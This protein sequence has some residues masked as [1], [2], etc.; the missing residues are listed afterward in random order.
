MKQVGQ[1]VR[2]I[3]WRAITSGRFAYTAD[4]ARD[5]VLHGQILR[6][7]HPFARILAIDVTAAMAAPGVRAVITAADFPAGARYLHEGAADRPPLA[8]GWVRFVGQEVAAVAADSPQQAQAALRLIR[9]RYRPLRKAPAT[10][11]A[12]RRIGAAKLHER[13]TGQANLS[14]AYERDWGD[15]D[16]GRRASVHVRSADYSFPAQ[17]HAC[18]EPAVTLADWSDQDERLQLWTST[19][20]PYYVVREVAKVMGLEERQVVCRE[21]GAGGSFGAR[22][23]VGDHEA[24]AGLLSRRAG[25]PVLIELTREEDFS[26]TKTRHAFQISLRLGGDAAHR[27]RLIEGDVTVDNGAYNH[28]GGSVMG[29]GI[30]G[31]GML[32]A[33]DGLKIAARLVDTAKRPGGQFRGYGTTQTSFALECLAD[34]L[35]EAG[36]CD[37]LEWRRL[38][39]NQPGDRTLVG[40]RIGTCLL[41][42]CLDAAGAAIGWRDA[43]ANPKPDEG[44]GVASAVHVSGSYADLKSNQSDSAVDIFADGRVRLRFGGADAGTGQK[45]ILAQIVA[46]ALGLAADQVAVMSMDS[47]Q[48]P[49]DMGA[50]SSRGTHYTGHAARE[51]AQLAAA[52]LRRLANGQIGPGDIRFA[53]G[54]AIGPLGEAS[55]GDLVQ[56]S[57]EGN[58]GVLT[59]EAAFVQDGVERSDPQTGLGN[60]S[61]SYN[62]A[63]HAARVR[64]DRRTGQV[65]VLDYV[66][67]HDVGQALNPTLVEGQIIGGTAMGL[68]SALGEEVIV[69]QGRMVNGAHLHYALPRAGDLPAIRPI[70]VGGSDAAGPHGAKGVGETGV[71]PPAA[72]IAN[73]IYDSVGVRLRHPPFT[74]D[75]VLEALGLQARDYGIWRRP[76]RWWIAV[77][78]WAYARGL[79]GWLHAR[80]LHR[81]GGPDLPRPLEAVS[82]PGTLRA[83]LD[84]LAQG[85]APVG[86]GTDLHLR[87]RLGFPVARRLASVTGAPELDGI[88]MGPD[89]WRIGAAVTLEALGAAV[90]GA[91]PALADAIAQIA[92]PQIRQVATLGGQL[93][94]TNRCWFLRNGFDCYKRRGGL[95]PC[96]AILGDHRFYHAALDGHRCQ[97]VTPSDLAGVLTAL[98]AVA[99][100]SGVDGHDRRIP[101][102]ALYTGPGETVLTSADLLTAVEIPAHAAGL[103]VAYRKLRLWQGDFALASVTVAAA[104][105]EDGVWRDVRICFGGLSPTPWRARQAEAALAGK[106]VSAAD[107]RRHLDR[108]F[109]AAAHPLAGNRWKIDAAIGLAEAAAQALLAQA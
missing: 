66:A 47:D 109:A 10:P 13:L 60:V 15:S 68:G 6:S 74:P 83:L 67:A 56:A 103:R 40:A 90:R 61:A 21:I 7:P 31:L 92:S 102:G 75:K 3:D 79:F 48:T 2:P 105:A 29:A 8:E 25:R 49:F 88:E 82:R 23:K 35:A 1:R 5:G 78:R 52:G 96:Y 94:Q 45:T 14:I 73:A 81:H 38:N 18:M 100:V 106:R 58:A 89:S 26:T 98:D 17:C 64:V 77:V 11:A 99:L 33:P 30:K 107:V 43:K 108:A 51:A 53:D 54:K 22:S 9:V 62:F 70:I 19:A 57:P 20:A 76:G 41:T 44:V 4:L 12:A 24:I 27:L 34:E 85:A 55:F 91:L 32:Y 84:D 46:E 97:S 104:I 65:T 28:S 86:G 16:A 69:E 87:R 59:F 39:A 101:F 63:A 36:G 42:E 72:A 71:N 37:P 95:A 50:W 93:L 80:A